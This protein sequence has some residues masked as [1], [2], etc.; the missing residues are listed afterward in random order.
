MIPEVI[1]TLTL[2]VAA[3]EES[4]TDII[5]VLD[6]FKYF[7]KTFEMNNEMQRAVSRLLTLVFNGKD[8]IKSRLISFFS[9]TYLDLNSQSL[10]QCLEELGKL[11][12]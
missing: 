5:A 12:E 3:A 9:D 11:I 6:A 4:S 7:R 2:V 8:T 10:E 1:K